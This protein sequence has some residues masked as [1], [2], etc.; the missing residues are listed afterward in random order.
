MSSQLSITPTESGDY[1]AHGHLDGNAASVSM[2]L[3]GARVYANLSIVTLGFSAEAAH[4]LGK[5]LIAA[6]QAMQARQ[7]SEK[8]GSI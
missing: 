6:A 2:S 8:E 5:H 1:A 4:E 3:Y 7:A